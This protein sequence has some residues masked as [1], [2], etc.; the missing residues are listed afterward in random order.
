MKLMRCGVLWLGLV[1][2]A[3]IGAGCSSELPRLDPTRYERQF[4]PIPDGAAPVLSWSG[5]RLELHSYWYEQDVHVSVRAWFPENMTK[6]SDARWVVRAQSGEGKPLPFLGFATTY[7][8][9]TGLEKRM[10][11]QDVDLKHAEDGLYV[12]LMPDMTLRDGKLERIVLDAWIYEIRDNLFMPFNARVPLVPEHVTDRTPLPK[13]IPA[14]P[15]GTMIP[16]G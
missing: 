13:P 16:G 14:K 5:E 10:L 3:V 8:T 1:A 15:A 2:L 6:A 9:D 12:V 11:D 7:R 4:P